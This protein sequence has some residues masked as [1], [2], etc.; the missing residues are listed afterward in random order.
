MVP[1]APVGLE[2]HGAAI[3]DPFAGRCGD[4]DGDESVDGVG[5]G[6]GVGDLDE[7]LFVGDEGLEGVYLRR[8]GWD[9]MLCWGELDC[10][11]G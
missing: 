2:D 3:A 8:E 7:L 11:T 4:G 5:E 1:V 10:A 6:G 9:C